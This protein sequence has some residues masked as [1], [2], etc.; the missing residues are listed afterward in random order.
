MPRHAVL[1]EKCGYE[2]IRIFIEQAVVSDA[3]TDYYIQ[4]RF[5]CV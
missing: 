4:I 3:K 5:S 2:C 1:C